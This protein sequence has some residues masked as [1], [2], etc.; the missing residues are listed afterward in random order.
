MLPF[1]L[2][3]WI[4]RLHISLSKT[5]RKNS[6]H[7]KTT[8]A[9]RSSTNCREIRDS[10]W[11][12]SSVKSNARNC[13]YNKCQ[14]T[15]WT[16]QASA[17]NTYHLLIFTKHKIIFAQSHKKYNRRYVFKTRNPL[18]SLW[19]L[20]TNVN[21]SANTNTQTAKYF[22][23]SYKMLQYNVNNIWSLKSQHLCRTQIA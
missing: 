16:E 23:N 17:V 8:D 10:K 14:Q 3:H 6:S 19:S 4:Y 12:W 11:L 15:K 18:F 13:Y 5:Y 7:F 21:D 2:H 22:R 20:T 1:S 9:N